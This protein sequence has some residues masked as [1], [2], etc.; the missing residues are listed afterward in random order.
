MLE[1]RTGDLVKITKGHWFNPPAGPGDILLLV[2][3]LI[4]FEVQYEMSFGKTEVI[5]H[6]EQSWLVMFPGGDVNVLTFGIQGKTDYEV[7]KVAV[8]KEK[9]CDVV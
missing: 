1:L 2:E 6:A 3:F 8:M 5:Q 4:L 7:E 9:C